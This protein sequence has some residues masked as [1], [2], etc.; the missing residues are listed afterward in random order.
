MCRHI[1]FIVFVYGGSRNAN[2]YGLNLLGFVQ[3][4]FWKSDIPNLFWWNDEIQNAASEQETTFKVLNIYYIITLPFEIVHQAASDLRFTHRK[5]NAQ[6]FSLGPYRRFWLKR[7]N[8]QISM[9]F[10]VIKCTHF[11]ID[12]QLHTNQ[13]TYVKTRHKNALNH[14]GGVVVGLFLKCSA[15]F[16]DRG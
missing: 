5:L 2:C 4:N 13:N 10:F 16:Y 7:F 8:I 11:R 15:Y 9:R 14:S 3:R 12:F 1:A 6:P